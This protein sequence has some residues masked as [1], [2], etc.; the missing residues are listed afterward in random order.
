MPNYI[1]VT[2][3]FLG[4]AFYELSGGREF[5]ADAAAQAR[6]SERQET[7]AAL[8]A[9]IAAAPPAELPAPR[10]ARETEPTPQPAV[11]RLEAPSEAQPT[12]AASIAP[13][14]TLASL[15]VT[16]EVAPEAQEETPEMDA[17]TNV[18]MQDM[19]IVR[20]NRAN[21]RGGPGTGHDVIATLDRGNKVE[22]LGDPVNGWVQLRVIE[23]N[24]IGWMAQSLLIQPDN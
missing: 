19:R 3:I 16:T 24:L 7:D 11:A 1:L 12:D 14:T 5:D 23:T 22:I 2:L 20:P 9:R 18:M 15:P 6:L 4:W 8:S 13:A 17:E 10:S 21:M